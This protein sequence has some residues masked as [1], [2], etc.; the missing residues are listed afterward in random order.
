MELKQWPSHF[1][2]RNLTDSF[3]I[4]EQHPLR[5][6]H[7]ACLINRPK[8]YDY[9]LIWLAGSAFLIIG[10]IRTEVSTCS[11]AFGFSRLLSVSISRRVTKPASR[12]LED[13]SSPGDSAGSSRLLVFQY[14]GGRREVPGD[15]ARAL[16]RDMVDFWHLLDVYPGQ[17][18][19]K[20]VGT[21]V[22]FPR[23]PL[24]KVENR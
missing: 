9:D 17:N 22:N 1:L 20:K 18:S 12:L 19:K 4:G 7:C 13:L 14:G 8:H 16:A 6:F 10:K 23:L 24:H 15:V 21:L 5:N 3:P 2:P 11:L